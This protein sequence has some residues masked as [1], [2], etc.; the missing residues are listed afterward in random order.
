MKNKFFDLMEE[1][2]G[3]DYLDGMTS[4]YAEALLKA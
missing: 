4:E 2:T 3:V 1:Y